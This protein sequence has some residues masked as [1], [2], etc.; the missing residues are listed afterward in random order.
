[1]RAAIWLL[2]SGGLIAVFGA[3]PVVLH[4][5]S[6]R[7]VAD[8]LQVDFG[9]A[10]GRPERYRVL[11]SSEVLRE[12]NLVVQFSG[13]RLQRNAA[14][15]VPSWAKV[16]N[17]VDTGILA[18]QIDLKTAS[19]WKINWDGNSLQ[20]NILNQVR[21]PSLWRNPWLIGGLGAS[22]L[23]GGTAFWLLGSDHAK[24]ISGGNLIPPPDISLPQ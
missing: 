11:A 15:K 6:W 3:E 10:N 22:F 13:V 12:K 7:V 8:S 23:A 4:S 17:S 24:A 1:M 9:F 5:L 18:I 21:S 20:L 2:L 16:L 14:F 19:P